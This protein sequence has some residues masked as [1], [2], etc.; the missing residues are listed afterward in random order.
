MPGKCHKCQTDFTEPSTC[1]RCDVEYCSRKCQINDW[2]THKKRCAR[3]RGAPAPAPETGSTRYDPGAGR[4]SPRRGLDQP[5]VAPFTRLEE[6]TYLYDRPE[7]DVYRILV[8]TYRL[9]MEDNLKIDGTREPDC[10]YSPGQ[11]DGLPGFRRFLAAAATKMRG[12]LLPP[13]WSEEKQKECEKLGAESGWYSL[14]SKITKADVIEHYG[15]DHFPMQL[16]MVGE[17]VWGIAPGGM[18]GTPMRQM[19]A[20]KE[21]GSLPGTSFVHIDASSA[22][23]NASR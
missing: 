1:E 12:R 18:N 21:S 5:I 19:L 13:W 22:D 2:K 8:D 4:P 9:R 10:I 23:V 3:T 15:D 11:T 16:R 20:M 6:G 17:F 14:K 7:Q